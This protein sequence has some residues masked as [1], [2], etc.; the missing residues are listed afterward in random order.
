M[1]FQYADFGATAQRPFSPLLSWLLPSAL[2]I[3]ALMAFAFA[4]GAFGLLGSGDGGAAAG[5]EIPSIGSITGASL[6]IGERPFAYLE[7]DWPPVSGV[8]GFEPLQEPLR[9]ADASA[10]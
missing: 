1:T 4:A 3:A 5:P 9:L 8:P 6:A 2:L 7:F 10:G